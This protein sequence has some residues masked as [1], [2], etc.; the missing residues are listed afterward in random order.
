MNVAL[1]PMTVD[2]YLAWLQEQPRGRFELVDGQVIAMNAQRV[3]H[4]LTKVS[5]IRGLEDALRATDF[6]ALGDGMAIRVDEH[7]VYEPDAVVYGGE[8]LKLGSVVLDRPILL[9]EILSPGTK[10]VDTTKKLE[11]Y[12]KL[13]TVRHYLIVD[14]VAQSVVHHIR[15]DSGTITTVLAEAGDLYLTALGVSVPLTSLFPKNQPR[16]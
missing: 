6:H 15:D 4:I 7:T 11:G 12:F 13:P 10:T 9:V 8:A 16:P 5:V 1:K 3:E 2:R 14:P